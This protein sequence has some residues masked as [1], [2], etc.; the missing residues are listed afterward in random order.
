M[1]KA[2]MRRAAAACAT[3]MVLVLGACGGKQYLAV[4]ESGD[5]TALPSNGAPATMPP[6]MQS[7]A[8]P[9]PAS[10]QCGAAALQYLVGKAKDEIPVA[11]VPSRR[12][13][14]CTTC[15][16]TMD[17]RPERQTIR[18]DEATKKVVS[19]TCG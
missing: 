8:R 15:P 3:G 10:D 6:P 14:A 13:V 17:V 1:G 12:R 18:Y 2:G 7:A 19:V 11:L 16:M 5:R 9:T 4:N